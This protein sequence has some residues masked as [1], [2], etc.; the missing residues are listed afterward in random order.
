MTTYY[1]SHES[2]YLCISEIKQILLKR[3]DEIP[4]EQWPELFDAMRDELDYA[5]TAYGFNGL[6]FEMVMA[7]GV[8][9]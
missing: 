4:V 2:L 3:L 1:Q 9:P 8:A 7:C 5:E 6:S